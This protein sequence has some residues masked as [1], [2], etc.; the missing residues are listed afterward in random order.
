M[1]RTS[2][3]PA[4]LLRLPAAREGAT[5]E[6]DGFDPINTGEYDRRGRQGPPTL[7][8]ADSERRQRWGRSTSVLI[9]LSLTATHGCTLTVPIWRVP[10]RLSTAWFALRPFG[11]IRS[12][13]CVVQ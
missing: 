3:A 9:C 1:R 13:L 8:E 11:P 4:R 6:G 10:R 2:I 12:D 7:T 5:F